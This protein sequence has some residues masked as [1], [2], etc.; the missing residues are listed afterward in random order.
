MYL[1]SYSLFKPGFFSR[2]H[3]IILK[4]LITESQDSGVKIVRMQVVVLFGR[5]NISNILV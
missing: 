4:K 2:E 3:N 1:F 5:K